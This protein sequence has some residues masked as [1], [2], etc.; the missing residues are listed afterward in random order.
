MK[1]LTSTLA[2]RGKKLLLI[3]AAGL[4]SFILPASQL[5][6]QSA[7]ISGAATICAGS[8]TN[9]T[10]DF[11]GTAPFTYSYSNGSVTF[12]PFVTSNNPELVSVSPISA[13]TYSLVSM[14]DAGGAGTV[15][16]SALVSVDAAPPV[17]SITSSGFVVPSSGCSGDVVNVSCNAVP[18]ATGYTWTTTAGTLVNGNASPFTTATNNASLTLGV[19]P[20]GQSYFGVCVYASNACGVSNARCKKIRGA[21][22][23]P[24]PIA[25]SVIACQNTSGNYNTTAVSGASTYNWTST[26]GIIINSGNGSTAVNI[27]F[28]AGFTQG[29]LCVNAALPCG[30]VSSDRCITISSGPSNLGTLTGSFAVC[31]G[32][33]GVA[34]SVPS[35]PAITSYT[36]TAPANATVA[37]G[38]GSNSITVDYTS[39]FTGGQV[40]VTG[41]SVCGASTAP[42]C[43]H[44]TS[45]VPGRP[46]NIV[47]Q[48]GG[49]CGL[50]LTYSVPPVSGATSYT[51]T[52][53]AAATI[54]SG[55]GT[56]T[57]DVSYPA[58]FTGG[59]I[60]VTADNACGTSPSRCINIKG[61]PSDPATI[62]GPAVICDAGLGLVYSI[63]NVPG[64]T[65]YIW[66]VPAGASIVS[67]QGTTSITVDWGTSSG[68]VTVIASN[69]CGNS[70]TETLN[71]IYSVTPSTPG[72]INGPEFVCAPQTGVV[73]YINSVPGAQGYLWYFAGTAGGAT[74][75]C[76]FIDSMLL[77]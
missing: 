8:S 65:G 53:P 42:R 60:C 20:P 19:L 12:G 7:I 26:G 33:T 45:G 4:A 21:L 31:P 77:V 44:V 71:V 43:K 5:Q 37:S 50:T 10:I 49:V 54:V 23:T 74:F 38:Q 13:T 14:S 56:S 15:S 35:D 11:T 64:A 66:S 24:G 62:S 58:G 1:T 57:V 46:G 9:L 68:L 25:G 67:G 17:G 3:T 59:Q 75:K 29:T 40:C 2:K 73:Y 22:S 69:A 51:W 52:V 70:G 76:A 34:Y 63:A 55:Q 28:P 36:W 30:T 18:N 61:I 72:A 39:G 41:T 32:T 27:T 6:A 47:G 48:T 16:G